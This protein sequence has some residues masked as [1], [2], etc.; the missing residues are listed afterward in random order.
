MRV[1]AVSDVHIDYE[2]NYRW[3]SNL[4]YADYKDDALILAGDVSGSMRLLEKA[5]TDLRQKFK[6][7]AFVP[8]NHD[9]W[10]SHKEGIS[11]FEKFSQIVDVSNS[12]G[13][14][15]EPFYFGNVT[16]VPLF[17]WYDYSFGEPYKEIQDAWADYFACKWPVDYDDN[18]IT[19]YFLGK[20]NISYTM[21]NEN[22]ISF[23]HFVPRIDIMPFYI[24][25][26][27]RKLYPML[28]SWKLDSQ[29]REL[30]S[31]I[32]V[33]G[34]SHVN[35]RTIKDGI[36]YLNNAFGYPYETQICAKKLVCVLEV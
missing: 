34:H 16:I 3:L 15:T 36:L 14:R 35:V 18:K 10:V 4:S 13:I 9:L 29:I 26:S 25:P 22:I 33:Y 7:V 31:K 21:E 28:G 12:F 20:N 27:R 17:G 6:E 5:F 24:P 1:F 30:G 11:S 32:H 19:Q 8:G 2:E 23:S